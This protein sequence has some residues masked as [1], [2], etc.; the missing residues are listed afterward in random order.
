[1][2]PKTFIKDLRRISRTSFHKGA[3]RRAKDDSTSSDV[4]GDGRTTNGTSTLTLD[5]CSSSS[6]HTTPPPSLPTLSSSYLPYL[7]K[8]E[9]SNHLGPLPQR[10]VPI[11]SPSSRS[12]GA[13]NHKVI[14]IYGQIGDARNPPVDGSVTLNH[15]NDSFPS[16]TWPVRESHF[17]ALLHLVPGPNKVRLDF[18]S[19]KVANA[20][21]H[22]SVISVNYLPM[23]NCPPLHL[24]ILLAKDSHGQFDTA[25]SASKKDNSLDVAV[26]KF[27]MAAYLWQAF[28][29][30]QMYRNNFARRSF[31]FEEEWQT[32][33]ISSKDAVSHQMRNEAKIHVIR[34]DKTVAELTELSLGRGHAPG[35]NN[36][37][38]EIVKAALDQRFMPPPG[39]KS[40]VTAL[41]LDNHFDSKLQSATGHARV[42]TADNGLELA[43]F[44]SRGLQS[45][46]SCIEEVVSAFTDCARPDTGPLANGNN[47]CGS[48][49]EMATASLGAHL[50]EIGRVF[51]CSERE[52]GIMSHDYLRFNRS[53]TSWE[54]YCTRTKEQGLRLC[55][56]QD[57]TSW[58]R[59]DALRFRLHPCFRHPSDPPPSSN[60]SI[61]VWAVDSSKIL[62]TS[63]SGVAF[64]EIYTDE[65]DICIAYFD[66]M[67]G[68]LGNSNNGLSKQVTVTEDEIRARLPENRKK[69]RK[70]KLV[71]VSGSLCSHT[72]EDVSLLKAKGSI[73]KLPNG[74][75]G[76][77]SNNL[78][79]AASLEAPPQDLILDSAV[80]QTKLLTSIKVH[81]SPSAVNGIEFCYE[82]ATSQFFGS[83]PSQP[84][85]I[86]EHILDTRRGE[87]LTGFYIRAAHKV[88]GLGIITSMGKINGVY[89]DATAGVGYVLLSSS[90]L[91]S[92]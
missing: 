46:P 43:V 66:Y 70:L 68:E 2:S 59:L 24:V 54:P 52:S 81:H 42:G 7:C 26:R 19:K 5:N 23:I 9:T 64:I 72:V 56:A 13:V 45:Y 74:Q 6:S 49:W 67:N 80:I 27:R 41:I 8:A 78:G 76:Y 39:Q 29:Q 62:L 89:G 20:T 36:E 3:A 11:S 33:T 83:Q 35:R 47:E 69:A 31:R 40:Y 60:G 21:A 63:M 90:S 22:Q 77:R 58:H 4:D 12:S 32:G 92:R 37:L 65:D 73:I 48:N 28:T 86:S 55:L 34:C 16:T 51:G 85:I 53:F 88:E 38:F 14:L 44:G 1:M 61:H 87:L 18:L 82:D 17:K 84:A 50:R 10:P 91:A 71:I 57:E 25:E 15:L 30:E 79:F 75:A